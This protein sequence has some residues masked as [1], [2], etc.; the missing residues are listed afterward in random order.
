MVLILGMH[1]SGTSA[2]TGVM[3]HLG[4]RLPKQIMEATENNPKGYFEGSAIYSFNQDLLKSTK[5]RWN[6]WRPIKQSW[7][8]S[9]DGQVMGSKAHDLITEEFG[10]APLVVLKDPRI[11]RMVPF[12]TDAAKMAGFEVLPILIHRNPLEVAKSL[13]KRDGID[14]P[15]GLLIWLRH[16]LDAEYS[17]RGSKRFVTSY[18]Q[19]LTDWP[20]QISLMQQTFDLTFPHFDGETSNAIE[21]FLSPNLRHHSEL[22][23][24]VINNDT[25][26]HWIRETYEILERWT[27]E[28][29]SKSDYDSLDRVRCEFDNAAP[30]FSQL[31]GPNSAQ[32]QS[33]KEMTAQIAAYEQKHNTLTKDVQNLETEIQHQNGQLLEARNALAQSR[34]E[35]KDHLQRAQKSESTQQDALQHKIETLDYQLKMMRNSTFWKLSKPLRMIV[36]TLRRRS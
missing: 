36:D 27:K 13:E 18:Q 7:L 35:A 14:L 26:S 1:R 12:W 34:K 15:E 8:S 24:K 33:I 29:A 6:D 9:P 22:P 31:I 20:A 11:C 28:K 32:G 3:N 30:V 17:T 4:C 23:E 19:M 5:S 10:D 25:L 21:T 2:T 16:V